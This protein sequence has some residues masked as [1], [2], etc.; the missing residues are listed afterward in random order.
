MCKIVGLQDSTRWHKMPIIS[1]SAFN[2]EKPMLQSKSTI[3][4]HL[5]I[6]IFFPLR[7]EK[8]KKEK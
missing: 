7:R 3:H 4:F 2:T 6:F 5:E 1:S 8:K